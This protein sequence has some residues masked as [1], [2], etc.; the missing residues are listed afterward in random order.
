MFKNELKLEN[1]LANLEK[2]GERKK[3]SVFCRIAQ[4]TKFMQKKLNVS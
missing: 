1:D 3:C 4:V 2:F